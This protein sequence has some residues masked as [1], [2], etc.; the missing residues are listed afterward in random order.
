MNITPML[1]VFASETSDGS[2]AL[3]DHLAENELAR[4]IDT[5]TFRQVRD[6][7]I[8]QNAD[9]VILHGRVKSYYVK[10]LATHAV[11][12]LIPGAAIENS[13]SVVN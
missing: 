4:R 11:L 5:L 3:A 6:L 1:D 13:I 12:E 10:Q 8:S 7:N 9:R 2:L